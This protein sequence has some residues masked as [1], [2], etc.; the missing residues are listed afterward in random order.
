VNG[1]LSEL[2]AETFSSDDEPPP[3]PVTARRHSAISERRIPPLYL[4][5]T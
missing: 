1:A 5:N 3:H 4:G 2:A